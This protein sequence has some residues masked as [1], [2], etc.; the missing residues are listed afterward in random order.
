M[1]PVAQAPIVLL[2]IRLDLD[3]YTGLH[4]NRHQITE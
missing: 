2:L 3:K 1:L 4:Y